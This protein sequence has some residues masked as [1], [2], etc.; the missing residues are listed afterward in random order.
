VAGGGGGGG[1]PTAASAQGVLLG[2]IGVATGKQGYLRRGSEVEQSR[3]DAY[4][5]METKRHVNAGGNISVV[6]DAAS[7]LAAQQTMQYSN[8][9]TTRLAMDDMDGYPM[10]DPIGAAAKSR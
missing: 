9:N 7:V 6:M 10:L 1:R 8:R 2:S 4:T 5:A 3:R